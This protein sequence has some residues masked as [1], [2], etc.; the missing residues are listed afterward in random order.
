M[1]LVWWWCGV[2]LWSVVHIYI[3]I[4]VCVQE[5]VSVKGC[6]SNVH[7]KTYKTKIKCNAM[8]YTTMHAP[9]S[10]WP[11]LA[12][13]PSARLQ[14]AVILP[15][16]IRKHSK[17][18]TGRQLMRLTTYVVCMCIVDVQY[19]IR[20]EEAVRKREGGRLADDDPI[21]RTRTRC[22]C[23]RNLHVLT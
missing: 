2:A 19:V 13:P 20:G 11:W 3:Y 10:C 16:R 17:T 5:G 21:T 4:Y 18:P 1:H 8:L 9:P 6:G 22:T 14:T 15:G 7:G 12:V 23:S